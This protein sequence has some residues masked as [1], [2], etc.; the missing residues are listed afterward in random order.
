LGWT[1]TFTNTLYLD[2]VRPALVELQETHDFG[3][4]VIC[5]TDPGFPGITHYDFVRW[6]GETEIEDLWEIDIG[7]M[8]L[9]DITMAKSKVGFKAIQYSALGIPSVVSDAGSGREV[10]EDRVTGLVVPNTTEGW[11]AAL[12]ELI[13]DE[14]LRRQMGEAARQK[15][16]SWYSVPAQESAYLRLFSKA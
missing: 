3:L 2:V 1:G 7:L 10:V 11:R 8:P 15:I 13:D 4:R 9:F 5:N 12:A 16:L 14:P 6:R